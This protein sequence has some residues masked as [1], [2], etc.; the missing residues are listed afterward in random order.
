VEILEPDLGP[1]GGDGGGEI[2]GWGP[3]EDNVKAARSLQ[4]SSGGRYMVRLSAT[5]G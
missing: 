4:V 5:S 2:V 1:K 3:P